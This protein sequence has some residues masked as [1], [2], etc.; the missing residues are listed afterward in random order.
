MTLQEIYYESLGN[1]SLE[2]AVENYNTFGL[3]LEV[4]DGKV[5]NEYIEKEVL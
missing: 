3:V 1:Q 2:A 4:N 5:S